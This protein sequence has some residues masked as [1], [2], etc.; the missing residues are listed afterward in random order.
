MP[1]N[2]LKSV[3]RR[4]RDSISG[5]RPRSLLMSERLA[6]EH[7]LAV[8]LQPTQAATADALTREYAEKLCAATRVGWAIVEDGKVLGCGG[9]VE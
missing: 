8:E 7:I 4:A 6:P 1:I 9:L 2:F 3:R 5:R